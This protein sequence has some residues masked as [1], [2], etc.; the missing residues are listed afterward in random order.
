MLLF[1]YKD[2]SFIYQ[3]VNPVLGGGTRQMLFF[4]DFRCGKIAGLKRFFPHRLQKKSAAA[5]NAA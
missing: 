1:F 5:E 2:A 3:P 4:R